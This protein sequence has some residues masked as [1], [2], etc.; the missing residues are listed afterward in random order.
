MRTDNE[1][2]SGQL[3]AERRAF[4]RKAGVFAA[5]SAFGL[6]FF[7]SCGENDDPAP[8]NPVPPGSGVDVDGSTVTIDLTEQPGLTQAGGW[9]LIAQAQVLVVNTGNNAFNALTS[10]CTHSACDR[11]WTFASN[12]FTCTCHSS[13]FDVEGNVL[14]GPASRPLRAYATSLDGDILTITK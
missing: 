13:R 1:I 14:S 9:M 12:V 4:I 2:R 6:G 11:N 10:V 7:T 3:S 5:M 8:I